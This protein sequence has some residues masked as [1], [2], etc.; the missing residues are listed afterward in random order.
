MNLMAGSLIQVGSYTILVKI[1]E[2]NLAD[3]NRMKMWLCPS[4]RR[5]VIYGALRP[6]QIELKPN[7]TAI[8]YKLY[9]PIQE[10]LDQKKFKSP[11]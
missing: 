6:E 1:K 2:E 11:R 10:K 5:F 8:E 9:K 3:A 7:P 4:I